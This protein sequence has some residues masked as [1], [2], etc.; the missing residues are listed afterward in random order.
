MSL[1]TRL[2]CLCLLAGSSS[3][4]CAHSPIAGVG[5]FY[6]GMLHPILVPAHVLAIFAVGLW[7]GQR[8]PADGLLLLAL[9]GAVPIGM[10]VGRFNVWQQGELAILALA[11]AVALLVAV[12]RNLPAPFPVAIAVA[13][14]LLIGLDSLPDG[15]SGRPLWLSLAGTWVAVLLGLAGMVAIS[16]I[17]TRP[18]MRIGVRVFA[19]W[20]CAAAVLVLA[21]SAFGP[22]TQSASAPPTVPAAR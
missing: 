19:S 2:I 4:A 11:S 16:E 6:G 10:V 20:M 7:L 12:A 14:G 1:S 18:W 13:F 21:L 5:H 3:L 22:R 8:W 15:L 17:A 9:L